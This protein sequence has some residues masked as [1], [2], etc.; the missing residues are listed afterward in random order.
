MGI[1]RCTTIAA[2][3]LSS[4]VCLVT[5]GGFASNSAAGATSGAASVGAS[6]DAGKATGEVTI[7]A[8]VPLQG[9]FE[10]TEETVERDNPGLGI[11]FDFQGP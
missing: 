7:L 3:S 2:V 1:S 9:A 8:V 4:T 5:C 11:I 6:G 10:G